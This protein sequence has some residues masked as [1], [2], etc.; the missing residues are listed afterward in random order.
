[1]SGLRHKAFSGASPSRR[2]G[3]RALPNS[4]AHPAEIRHNGVCRLVILSQCLSRPESLCVEFIKTYPRPVIATIYSARR[5]SPAAKCS[6]IFD[7]ILCLGQLARAGY[8]S[9]EEDG[10]RPTPCS[11]GGFNERDNSRLGGLW[12]AHG[13]LPP[14]NQR[15]TAEDG[16]GHN[17][18]PSAWREIYIVQEE[19]LQRWRLR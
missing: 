11:H 18:V 15:Q 4:F 13:R 1:M 8:R 3:T 19:V 10:E 2:W 16:R 12:P 14:K 6:T 9:N 17:Q 7:H 5:C